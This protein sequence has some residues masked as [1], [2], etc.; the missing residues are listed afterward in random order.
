MKGKGKDV[1]MDVLIDDEKV[2]GGKIQ[3]MGQTGG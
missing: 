1:D 3:Q 2:P